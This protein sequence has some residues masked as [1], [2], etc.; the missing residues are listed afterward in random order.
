MS[1][2]VIG[3]PVSTF[4]SQ[5]LSQGENPAFIAKL[6]GH[7]NADMVLRVY[8]RWISEGEALGFDRPPRRFGMDLLCLNERGINT[9]AGT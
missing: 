5:L 9:K 2:P 3:L 4:A 1:A 8:G 6:L 7:K